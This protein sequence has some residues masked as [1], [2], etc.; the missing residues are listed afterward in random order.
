MVTSKKNLLLVYPICESSYWD[1]QH[2][3]DLFPKPESHSPPLGLLTVA[4]LLPDYHDI[5]VID[6]N[7][8]A[9]LAEQDILWADYVL[10]S[11]ML[12][13]ST[14]F[15]QV[16]QQC[17]RLDRP[18]VV[19]GPFPTSYRREIEAHFNGQRGVDCYVLKSDG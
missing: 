6:M 18:T 2:F 12:P 17:N 15:Y 9:P 3:L 8:N 1:F 14:S 13:Q 7:C 11:A 5:K 16:I 4:A 19:G 10:I